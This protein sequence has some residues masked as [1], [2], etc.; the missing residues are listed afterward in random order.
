MSVGAFRRRNSRNP[1]CRP[2]SG[3][4]RA[5]PGRDGGLHVGGNQARRLLPY[6]GP[7]ATTGVRAHLRSEEPHPAEISR[8]LMTSWMAGWKRKD[9][10]TA[11]GDP[12]RTRRS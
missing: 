8:L 2:V 4:V 1:N 12:L 10:K 5:R 9:W 11:S 6:V 7:S 3:Y